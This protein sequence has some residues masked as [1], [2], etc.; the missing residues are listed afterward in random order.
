VRVHG[1]VTCDELPLQA[2][3]VGDE[4]F[5]ADVPVDPDKLYHRTEPRSYNQ[6]HGTATVANRKVFYLAYRGGE[7]T[8]VKAG[9]VVKCTGDS[10]ITVDVLKNGTTILSTPI[11]L[12]S[13]NTNF[14]SVAGVLDSNPDPH[15]Y[16]EDSVFE[17]A[18]TV[19]AGSGTLGQGLF[20]HMNGSE[21]PY[22]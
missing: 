16:V 5:K 9:C 19:S 6:P 4:E 3:S 14:V 7:I 11:V 18:V 15:E 22:D 20:V 12:D 8:T 2:G 17:V 21:H 10:T 1:R 13:S